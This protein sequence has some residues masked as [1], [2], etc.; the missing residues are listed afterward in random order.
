MPPQIPKVSLAFA[1]DTDNNLDVFSGNNVI[2]LTG[3]AAFPDLTVPVP[4]LGILQVNFH[5]AL[6]ASATGGTQATALKN[7]TRLPLVAAMRLNAPYIQGRPGLTLSM[8]LSSGYL[9][10]NVNHSQSELVTPTLTI[11]NGN[12]TQ[13]IAHLTSVANAR[14]YQ[15]QVMTPDGKVVATVVSP[16]ARN[17]VI[18]GL[19]PGTSYT[20]QG[21]AVGGS[22]GFSDWSDPVSH[23]AM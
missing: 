14:S 17:V 2:C 21:R 19:L 15:V 12:T 11:D 20:L 16:Q 1:F 6:M 7:E 10:I 23:M 22:T 9:A 8:L 3:N 4:A 18:P 5:N 13:L